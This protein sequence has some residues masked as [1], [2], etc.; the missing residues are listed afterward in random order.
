MDLTI[1]SLPVGLIHPDGASAT[2]EALLNESWMAYRQRF[3]QA[4]GRVIDWEAQA[5]TVSEGQAYAMLRAVLTDDPDT[6]EQ[7]LAWA[8]TNLK[9]PA[10]PNDADG[11]DR[12]W[13]WQWGQR[14][15]QTPRPRQRWQ[16]SRSGRAAGA[17][18]QGGEEATEA[19]AAASAGGAA[20]KAAGR[21]CTRDGAGCQPG[22]GE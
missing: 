10:L 8:E 14:P 9:R 2:P 12:L 18:A 3:I 17:D 16:G 19:E 22:T 4:D 20:G 13:A 7:T 11:R 15:Q 21:G 1:G 5:R 6:F